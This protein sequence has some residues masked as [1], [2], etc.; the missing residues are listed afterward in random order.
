MAS[1]YNHFTDDEREELQML[2][3]EG[4]SKSDIALLLGKHRS[5]I[6]KEISR[7]R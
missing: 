5:T 4:R 6:Y 7:N 2:I 3:M 1:G